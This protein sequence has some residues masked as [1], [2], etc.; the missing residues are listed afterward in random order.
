MFGALMGLFVVIVIGLLGLWRER[1]RKLRPEEFDWNDAVT[2]ILEAQ[3]PRKGS[4]GE[5]ERWW[6]DTQSDKARIK[7][8]EKLVSNSDRQLMSRK[9]IDTEMVA[10]SIQFE[11]IETLSSPP[12]IMVLPKGVSYYDITKPTVAGL[13][14]EGPLADLLMDQRSDNNIH[15]IRIKHGRVIDWSSEPDYNEGALWQY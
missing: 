15:T 4:V 5:L 7:Q 8:L 11:N 12:K 6:N 2:N 1:P 14:V 10:S 9:S 3:H 13:K